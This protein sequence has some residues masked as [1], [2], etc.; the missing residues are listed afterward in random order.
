MMPNTWRAAV[1]LR[2]RSRAGSPAAQAKAQ[3]P[4]AGAGGKAIAAGLALAM[5]MP[6]SALPAFADEGRKDLPAAEHASHAEGPSTDEASSATGFD[7]EDAAQPREMLSA[8]AAQEAP[9]VR[10]G[11]SAPAELTALK[12][13]SRYDEEI[14]ALGSVGEVSGG[15]V[16][17]T[18]GEKGG[19]GV[20]TELLL[21]QRFLVDAAGYDK[22]LAWANED[23]D[24]AKFLQWLL[25]DYE[26]LQLYVTGG[27]PGGRDGRGSDHVQ[28][29]SQLKDLMAA[30]P[31]DLKDD[32]SDRRVYRTMMV[33]AALGVNDFTRL[34]V[35]NKNT[36]ADPVK[37]YE[38]IKTFR[39]H[40]E[41]YRFQKDIFDALPV[42]TMRWIFEN[43]IADEELPWLANYTLDYTKAD[44]S[45][46][47]EGER[48]NRTPSSNTT[49][50]GRIPTRR[51]T[52]STTCSKRRKASKSLQAR[53]FPAVGARVT[54]SSTTTRTS[55][56]KT[57][58]IRSTCLI[59]R[60]SRR[61]NTSVSGCR[62]SEAACAARSARRP[63][64]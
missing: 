19:I 4:A 57:R 38:I 34:W 30:H 24:N 56:M 62:S 7:G 51:F 64:T 61:M 28:A 9:G 12:T 48:L 16:S 31:E 11:A 26:T 32:V 5:A 20:Q 54:G 42:E 35:G 10:Q 47:D 21:L 2:I 29:I 6:L 23:A 40:A 58:A 33:S 60:A 44:G 37:R 13:V 52:T 8:D 45:K 59:T 18:P 49:A 22:L 17:G 36:P 27:R 53:L 63:R 1:P 14:R 39:V 55:P 3:G 15:I 46:L 25:T 50:P 41:H 43:R